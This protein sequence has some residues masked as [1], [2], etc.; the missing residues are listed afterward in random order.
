MVKKLEQWT[1]AVESSVRRDYSR[2]DLAGYDFTGADLRWAKLVDTD[3]T[4]A[5][6]TGA[7]LR[8]AN[9]DGADLTDADMTGVKWNKRTIWPSGFTPTTEMSTPPPAST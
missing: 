7:D 1:A 8:W 5:D 4:G 3:L 9:L 6:F 2:A